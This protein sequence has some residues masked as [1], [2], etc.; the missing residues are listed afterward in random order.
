MEP[1]A[2]PPRSIARRL[3]R[4]ALQALTLLSLAMAAF[5][6]VGVAHD[7]RW[8]VR[9]PPADDGVQ[10]FLSANRSSLC[11]C[12]RTP[13]DDSKLFAAQWVALAQPRVK[14]H[15]EYLFHGFVY[16]RGWIPVRGLGARG[17]GIKW[18]D[19]WLIVGVPSVLA[20]PLLLAL[21]AS[22]LSRW[23]RTL[24]RR[25]RQRSGLCESCGYDLR[26]T[27]DLCPECGLTASVA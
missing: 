14:V 23:R 3:R 15:K 9:F 18:I 17:P 1:P 4:Y 26:A 13:V 21:P 11:L 27:P 6:A 8:G 2:P 16:V 5:T 10:T 20:L 24:R 19:D 12:H 7:Q 25:R 22:R